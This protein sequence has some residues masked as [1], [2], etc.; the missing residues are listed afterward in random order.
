MSMASTC[1]SVLLLGMPIS[2]SRHDLSALKPSYC[3]LLLVSTTLSPTTLDLLFSYRRVLPLLL[4][5]TRVTT[6][7]CRGNKCWCGG[8]DICVSSSSKSSARTSI[9]RR[10][11]CGY[12]GGNT[13]SQL[14]F[15]ARSRRK[16]ASPAP[17]LAVVAHARCVWSFIVYRRLVVDAV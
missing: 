14:L 1:V 3:L 9:L 17:C 10:C 11:I 16:T 7:R 15:L 4:L 8:Q 2:S 6:S 12:E 5:P 13:S